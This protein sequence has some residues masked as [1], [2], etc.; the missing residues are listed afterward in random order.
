MVASYNPQFP[1]PSFDWMSD[2]LSSELAEFKL[3][4]E[5]AFIGPI[6]TAKEAARLAYVLLWL[7]R[8]GRDIYN[9][10]DVEDSQK[11]LTTLWAYLREYVE[12]R[13][14]FW[15]SRINLQRLKQE[16]EEPVD[17]YITRLRLQSQKCDF[18]DNTEVQQGL[19]EQLIYGIR[20]NA[21]QDWMLTQ[22][23]SMSLDNA[24]QHARAH[25]AK[26]ADIATF[27]QGNPAHTSV[28]QI[29]RNPT[30]RRNYDTNSPSTSAQ[31]S[32][33]GYTCPNCTRSHIGKESCPARTARC[34]NCQQKG[35]WAAKC[36]SRKPTTQHRHHEIK[37]ETFDK[38]VFDTV[39]SRDEAFTDV[40][41]SYHG[42]NA[43]LRA[44]VDTGAQGNLLPIRTFNKM[45]PLDSDRPHLQKNN[46]CLSVYDGSALQQYGKFE[47]TI[48]SGRNQTKAT[49]YV[50]D[51]PGPILLGFPSSIALKL[52]TMH[53][54]FNK[55][56]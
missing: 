39:T 8:T 46:T 54:A 31:S 27:R 45:Y 30:P 22:G 42:R 19:T 10:W 16:R 56:S 2:N 44:K 35:H 18:R 51:T 5:L 24:L 37:K 33:S 23:K 13:T 4:S 38:V 20:D 1:T 43:Y 26:L 32:S 53:C 25:E 12:P 48:S 50:V 17:A 29:R 41:F 3:Q 52:V 28:N 21:V 34:F 7:G 14:N 15:L 55:S 11:N 40:C 9:A 6:S 36:R 49:F 47:L